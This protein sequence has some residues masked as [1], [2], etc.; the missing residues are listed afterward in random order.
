MSKAS[1]I[2]LKMSDERIV[3]TGLLASQ[4]FCSRIIPIMNYDAFT[5]SWIRK[6]VEWSVEYFNE[7][8][9]PIFTN[10]QTKFETEQQGLDDEE[11]ELIAQFLEKVSEEFDR[12]KEYFNDVYYIDKAID[13]FRRQTIIA[14]KDKLDACIET[15]DINSAFDY[16][17]NVRE[18]LNDKSKICKLYDPNELPTFFSEDGEESKGIL[19]ID[20]ALGDTLGILERGMLIAFLAP[21]KRGK[22]WILLYLAYLCMLQRLNVLYISHEMSEKEAKQR[23]YSIILKKSWNKKDYIQYPK[24]D[25]VKN[26]DGSCDLP[27]RKGGGEYGTQYYRPCSVCNAEKKE[28]FE[29]EIFLL[30]KEGNRITPEELDRKM[31]AFSFMHERY[32]RMRCVAFGTNWPTVKSTIEMLEN[33]EDWVPDVIIEDYIKIR[34]PYKFGLNNLSQI[35]MIDMNWKETKAY[36]TTKGYLWITG[37]QGTRDTVRKKTLHADDTSGF[38]DI[39]GHVNK[40]FGLN[41]TPKE[42]ENGILRIN[43]LANRH[44]DY[45]T[46]KFCTVLQNVGFGGVV[47]DSCSGIVRSMNKSKDSD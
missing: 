25:C 9:K 36:T 38:I 46:E 10:I 12:I 14:T 2:T 47:L 18:T 33:N 21:M 6:I 30:R 45:N 39:V 16:L 24:F 8:K 31:T 29:P 42:K 15:G 5:L 44:E 13:F 26:R 11:K 4:A 32:F 3:V 43:V 41:Q 22:T 23:L 37:H 1:L 40:L 17:S 35:E 27:I 28:E 19:H 7:Y 34:S 20:G